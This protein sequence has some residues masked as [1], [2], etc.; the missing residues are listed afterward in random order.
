MPIRMNWAVDI[1]KAGGS[2]LLAGHAGRQ[3]NHHRVETGAEAGWE[4]AGKGP[5][6]QDAESTEC[7]CDAIEI[8]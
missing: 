2:V 5:Q 3:K 7:S 8:R 4:K 6:V 1:C